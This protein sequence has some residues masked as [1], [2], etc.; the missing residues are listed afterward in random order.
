MQTLSNQLFM[1]QYTEAAG[2]MTADITSD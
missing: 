2:Q 1:V